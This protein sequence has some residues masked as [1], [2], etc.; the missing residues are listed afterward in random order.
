M[1]SRPSHYRRS[2]DWQKRKYN[3]TKK[4]TIGG[5]IREEA[6]NVGKVLGGGG[7]TVYNKLYFELLDVLRKTQY[8][9][10][11]T[12]GFLWIVK[13]YKITPWT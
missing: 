11:Q 4:N 1:Y 6:V 12:L 10:S 9:H 13:N 8:C 7:A 2:R 3:I 5:S